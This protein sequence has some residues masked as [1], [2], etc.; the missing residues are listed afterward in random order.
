MYYDGTQESLSKNDSL[1]GDDLDNSIIESGTIKFS[2]P[3]F[4][5]KEDVTLDYQIG[6]A[7]V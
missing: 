7:H 3:H 2:F 5:H 4:S 6:R 1:C